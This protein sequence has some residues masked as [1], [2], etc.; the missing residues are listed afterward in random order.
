MATQAAAGEARSTG[1]VLDMNPG[2]IVDAEAERRREL[3]V[4][5]LTDD[6]VDV[7]VGVARARVVD[8]QRLRRAV[9]DRDDAFRFALVVDDAEQQTVDRHR[10][11]PEQNLTR[12]E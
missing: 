4:A 8:L 1:H 12:I 5:R 6:D 3:D 2:K 9:P 10:I 11:G 7:R